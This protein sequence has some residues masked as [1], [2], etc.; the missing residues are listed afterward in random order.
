MLKTRFTDLGRPQPVRLVRLCFA[1]LG[2]I[3]GRLVGRQPADA[4][5]R[6]WWGGGH[7]LT[8][9]ILFARELEK[10]FGQG[11]VLCAS[12][13]TEPRSWARWRCR[14]NAPGGPGSSRGGGGWLELEGS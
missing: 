8:P 3:A 7:G 1:K 2:E 13:N 6:A 10:F 9:R 12:G 4:H 11:V 14:D 5:G